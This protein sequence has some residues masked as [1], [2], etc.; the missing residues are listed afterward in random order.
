MVAGTGEHVGTGGSR[1]AAAGVALAFQA[2]GDPFHTTS[3]PLFRPGP[4]CTGSPAGRS[5]PGA[6][7]QCPPPTEAPP[8][9]SQR[10]RA[11][12]DRAAVL[13][14]R[15]WIAPLSSSRSRPAAE[16]TVMAKIAARRRSGAR[17]GC[18]DECFGRVKRSHDAKGFDGKT[19]GIRRRAVFFRSRRMSEKTFAI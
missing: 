2:D 17:R 13:S 4:C 3:L 14:D 7:Q 5:A 8:P 15:S 16:R 18:D 11:G 10:P 9:T 6:W 19:K 1:D 12:W